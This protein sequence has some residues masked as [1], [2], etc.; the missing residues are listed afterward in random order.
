LLAFHHQEYHLP[1]KALIAPN[2]GILV[3]QLLL[4]FLKPVGLYLN[5]FI[6]SPVG[7]VLAQRGSGE[8]FSPDALLSRTNG[9]IFQLAAVIWSTNVTV[10]ITSV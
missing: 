10:P 4:N 6:F 7:N 3:L 9:S 8:R 2:V 5:G 1:R